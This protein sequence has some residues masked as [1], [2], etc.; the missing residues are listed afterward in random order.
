MY[1]APD[2][3]ITILKDIPLDNTYTNTLY[4]ASASAQSSYF[5]SKAKYTF[6]NYTY[7]RKEQ[8]IR[9]ETKV[10]NLYDCNYIMFKNT[11]YGNKWFYAFITNVEYVNNEQ[12]NISYEIDVMQTWAFDYTIHPSLVVREHPL[13]DEIGDNLQPEGLETGTY[14]GRRFDA[15]GHLTNYKIIV[16]CTF[17]KEY[18]DSA[19][20]EYGNIYSGLNLNAFDTPEEVNT[21][22]DGAQNRAKADGIVSVFMMPGDFVVGKG[23]A[24]KTYELPFIRRVSDIDGYT[25]NNNKLFTYPY[26]YLYVTNLTGNSA[27]YKYEFFSGDVGS[28]VKFL[29]TMNMSCNPEAVLAPLNYKGLVAN[30]NEKLVIGDYPICSYNTDTFKAFLANSVVSTGTGLAST[31]ASATLTRDSAILKASSAATAAGAGA[32]LLGGSIGLAAIGVGAAVGAATLLAK[33]TYEAFQPPISNGSQGSSAML[34]L[35]IKDFAFIPVSITSEFAKVIDGYFDMYGY[36]TNTVKVPNTH[37]RKHWN[38]VLLQ[39]PSITGS[40][41]VGDIGKIKAIFSNGITFW[42][43]GNEVGHYEL[44]SDNKA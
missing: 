20:G 38:F 6:S 35:A 24:L 2:S 11:S 23:E 26:N 18:N 16:A 34:S 37:S 42:K 30:Y 5:A 7:L 39:N 8:V 33:A 29:L 14:V 22:I 21:F 32:A 31:F 43:N 44:A 28:S 40:I 9:V 15:T 4:F 1:I 25:P 36:A 17:D 10:D 19:G 41:P 13:T 3:I 27:E 12:A